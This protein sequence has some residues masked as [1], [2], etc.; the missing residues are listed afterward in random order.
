M[1]RNV[2]SW[3]WFDVVLIGAIWIALLLASTVVITLA[4][5]PPRGSAPDTVSLP[6]TAG[7]LAAQAGSLILAVQLALLW[8][9]KRWS[10]LGLA[11]TSTRWLVGAAGLGVGL[12]AASIPVGMLLQA[13][14]VE[15][16]NPQLLFLLPGGRIELPGMLIIG[17][18]VGVA[19]PFAEETFFRG[20]I[21]SSLRR[22][23][24][25]VAVIGSTLIFVLAH[26]DLLVGVYALMLGVATSLVYERSRSL[27]AA[28]VVHA[29]FN[30]LGVAMLY[31]AVALG[32]QLPGAS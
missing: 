23:G 27:W 6:Y 31:L 24:A 19:A 9:G 20:V 15:G 2:T 5:Q 13:L 16:E 4:L 8:R 7:M 1:I 22:W 3:R 14:G 26:L 18:I 28:V 12:R 17:L 11:Q 25:P 30:T 32:V 10:D 29:V 21:Y